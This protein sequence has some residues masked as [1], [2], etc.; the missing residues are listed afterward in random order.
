MQVFEPLSTINLFWELDRSF[1]ILSE[2][3]WRWPEFL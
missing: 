3:I 2:L 1:A